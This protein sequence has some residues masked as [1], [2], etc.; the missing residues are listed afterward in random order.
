MGQELARL[1]LPE[2]QHEASTKRPLDADAEV[3]ETTWDLLVS[4]ARAVRGAPDMLGRPTAV[5]DPAAELRR[6]VGPTAARALRWCPDVGWQRSDDHLAPTQ[7]LVDLYL[8]VCS[9]GPERVLTLGHLGQSLDGFIATESGD[10]CFVTGPENI[11]HMHRLRALC[12]AVLV[13]PGTVAADDPQLTTRLVRGANPTRVI[14]DPARRL[15]QDYQVFRDRVAPT[16]LV[17]GDDHEFEG[18]PPP[19]VTELVPVAC[20]DGDLD[21]EELLTA[22]HRRG[23]SAVFVEGGGVT[24]SK[25]LAAG[26]LDRLHLAVAPLLIGTGRP[27]IRLPAPTRLRECLRPHHRVFRMGQDV[28]FDCDLRASTPTD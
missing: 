6:L 19:G 20:T 15:T 2:H 10:S 23:L 28:L 13:G 27:A 11:R 18:T 9:A 7:E 1:G 22:L 16:L 24:V 14:V 5:E 3:V 12:D 21:F 4:A 25:F 17:C 26:L 8:P